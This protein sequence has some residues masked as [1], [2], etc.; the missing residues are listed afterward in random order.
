MESVNLSEL[1]FPQLA[2]LSC[3]KSSLSFSG[4]VFGTFVLPFISIIT[5]LLNLIVIVAISHFRQLHTPTNLL[6]LSL[7]IAD[8]IVGL[9]M[10]PAQIYSTASCWL[11]GDIVCVLFMLIMVLVTAASVG[12]VVLI[13]ADRYVAI[14]DP[15]RYNVRITVKRIQLCVC[16]CWLSSL[17]CCCIIFNDNLTHPGKLNSCYGECVISVDIDS[18]IIDVILSFILPL[19]IIVTLYSRVFVVALSQARAV[20]FHVKRGT[21]QTGVKKSELKAARTLG[22]LVLVFLA[23]F[24]PYFIDSFVNNSKKMSQHKIFVLHLFFFNSCVNPLLYAFFFP[25]FRRAVQLIVTLRILRP[26]SRE[27]KVM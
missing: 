8:A 17:L 6:L 16:L 4:G 2:N 5:V 10:I 27:V 1:C 23:C 12:N 7:A 9:L 25:W 24:C 19:S 18:G 20:R 14:C 13:S 21:A 15:L 22:V 3:K 26:G 11:L